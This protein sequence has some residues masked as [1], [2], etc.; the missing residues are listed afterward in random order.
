MIPRDSNFIFPI[1]VISLLVLTPAVATGADVSELVD[2][3]DEN[4]HQRALGHQGRRARP[5]PIQRAIDAYS[6]ALA[7][8]PESLEARWKLLRALYFQGEFVLEDIDARLELF[9]RGREIGDVGRQQIERHYDLSEDS[10]EMKP[11]EVADAIGRDTLAAEVYFWSST[12]WGL[13]GQYRGKIAAAR[14][15][16]ATKIRK[17]AEIVILLDERI[18]N[19]GGHRVLGRLHAEAPKIPL[20]TGWI[21]RDKAISELRR[22]LELA[23]DDLLTNLFLAEAL[24]EFRSEKRL[25]ALDILRAIAASEPSNEWRVEDSKTIEDAQALLADQ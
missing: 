19:A 16:V 9:E 18:E 21:S 3:G 7:V 24:L 13:W 12:H 1:L 8:D 15:G 25:E 22:A 10:L 2:R 11:R 6:E 17:F 20:V 5:E 4:Y 23:P 14:Q